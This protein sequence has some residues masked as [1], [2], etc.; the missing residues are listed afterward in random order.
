MKKISTSA[1]ARTSADGRPDWKAQ[2]RLAFGTKAET[3]EALAGRLATARVLPQARIEAWEWKK[4]P[5]LLW[6]RVLAAGWGAGSLI[7]RSSSR[8]EDRSGNSLAGHFLSV[9][10]ACGETEVQEAARRVFDSYGEGSPTDQVFVQPML[11]SPRSCGVAFTRDPNTGSPYLVV[12]LDESGSTDSVTSGSS[13]DTATYIL[14]RGPECRPV[15]GLEALPPLVEELEGLFGPSPLD[16]EFAVDREERLVLLQVR[17]LSCRTCPVGD[18][19]VARSL[20]DIHAKIEASCRKHP[21]LHGSRAVFGVMPD[22]NPAEIIG[23]RPQPLALSLYKELV[24]DSIWAYQ[25]DNYGYKNLRSFPLLIHFHGLPYIDVRVSFN[26]FV[27]ADVEPRLAERLVDHYLDRLVAMPA[28][29]DKVE[30]EIIYSCYTLDLPTR[31]G[32]LRAAGF[33]EA[34]CSSLEGSL[35]RLTNRICGGQNGLWRHDYAKVE[36]LASRLD[37]VR[38]SDLDPV[39]KIY[40]IL[41]DCKRYGTLPFAGL[42]RAGFIAVQL[43]RS[44]VAVDVLTPRDYNDYMRGLDTISSRMGKDFARMDRTEFLA[45]YGHLRPG[46]YD[47]LSPRYDEDPAR[48]FDWNAQPGPQVPEH[49]PFA[50]SLSQLAR[51]EAL[52]KEH[53]LT[54]DILRLFDFIKGGIEGREYAKFVFTRSLSEALSQF[55]DLAAAHGFSRE[56]CAYADISVIRELHGSSADVKETLARSIDSGRRAHAK[57]RAILL[58]PLITSPS[59]V[60]AFRVPRCEPNYITLGKATGPVTTVSDGREALKGAILFIPSA[61]PGYD[62]IFAQGIAGFV[63]MYGG[64]NSHM[65]IRAGELGIPSV[66]GA[67]EDLYTRWSKARSVEIDCAQR[68]VEILR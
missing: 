50:L 32:Q 45:S 52:L 47:I 59:E 60:Y 8:A 65:A 30:F 64:T 38:A 16:I 12:N 63:T 7:V 13:N 53:G 31:I 44:M 4:R 56:D 48:Y 37:T 43:L 62:W 20:A 51:I 39:S 14:H 11:E 3:L 58:P 27:P 34:D 54:N 1:A 23:L 35:R 24:T 9:S 29:H 25:R 55:G 68:R 18:E 42:A 5:S 66:I 19:D 6:E 61:D 46:T 67:G 15:P 36:M 33:S 17:P 41:E 21:Y 40:W 49:P 28:H 22:W 57:T 2:A 26:S 10:G